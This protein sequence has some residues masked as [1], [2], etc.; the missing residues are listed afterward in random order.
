ML[1]SLVKQETFNF[2][3]F[4]STKYIA[5]YFTNILEGIFVEL[6]DKI[7]LNILSK[8]SVVIYSEK[9]PLLKP[10]MWA[11]SFCLG[12]WVW[13]EEKATTVVAMFPVVTATRDTLW[14]NQQEH[15]TARHVWGVG[16]CVLVLPL[17][18]RF[19]HAELSLGLDQH[20]PGWPAVSD[21][22]MDDKV[23]CIQWRIAGQPFVGWK[24]NVWHRAEVIWTIWWIKTYIYAY[25]H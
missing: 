20:G 10:R 13:P 7:I 23:A 1:Y 4:I 5:L 8:T 12:Y 15:G 14:N 16:V 18:Q 25:T 11:L 2:N 19:L 21:R 17:V 9:K 24:C 22:H 6:H 3:N